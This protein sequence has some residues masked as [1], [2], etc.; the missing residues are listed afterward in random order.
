[1]NLSRRSVRPF[2]FLV[3]L[4]AARTG[5][6]G[7]QV[8]YRMVPHP[9]S[10]VELPRISLSERPAVE[11]AVNEFLESTAADMMCQS[12][13]PTEDQE[14]SASVEVTYAENDVLSISIHASGFCGGAHPIVG[15]N[16][17][18]T[19]DLLTGRPVSFRELF[20]DYERDAAE[21]ATAYLAS[22]SAEALEGC[23]EDF[24][25]LEMYGFSYTLSRQG[26]VIQPEFPHVMVACAHPSMVPFERILGLASKESILIRVARPSRHAFVRLRS[27]LGLR[28]RTSP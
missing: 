11:Q 24:D 9:V 16:H 7:G 19:F 4:G 14:Y 17:S 26:V 23:E 1:M 5:P 6:H 25:A 27:T 13:T 2:I 15:A 8:D 12:D 3:L 20:E 22:L 21:I 28:G 10:G 18:V